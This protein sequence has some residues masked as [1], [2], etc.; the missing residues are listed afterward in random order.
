MLLIVAHRFLR[1]DLTKDW[2]AQLH[3][4]VVLLGLLLVATLYDLFRGRLRLRLLFPMVIQWA[5]WGWAGIT[6]VV[7]DGPATLRA[8]ATH[9]FTKDLIFATLISVFFDSVRKLKQLAWVFVAVLT[10]VALVTL[11]QRDG[12]RKCFHYRFADVLGYNQLADNRPCATAAECYNVPQ[13]ESEWKDDGWACEHEGP[14]GLATVIDRIHYVGNL[15]DPNAQAQALVMACALALGLLF[16]PQTGRE[17]PF[18]RTLIRLAL[19]AALVVM[20]LAVYYAASRAAQAALGVTLLCFFYTRIGPIGTLIGAAGGL[21]L[22]LLSRRNQVEAAY[23]TLTRIETQ[24]NGYMAFLDQ[25]L[26]GVGFGN[27]EK[28]SFITAHNSFLLSATEAGVIGSAL[29]VLAVYVSFKLLFQVVRWP[30]PEPE[31]EDDPDGQ[32]PPERNFAPTYDEN[33]HEIEEFEPDENDENDGEAGAAEIIE[34]KHL[35]MT[36]LSMLVGVGWCVTFLSLSYD[37]MWLFPVGIVA[38]FYGVSR[39]RLPEFEMRLSIWEILLVLLL[40]G[41]LPAIFAVI[42]TRGW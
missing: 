36:L 14:W 5:A 35:G 31:P 4:P 29:F 2:V 22:A 7:A 20:G 3:P 33:G 28:I 42:A 40:G 27:Y 37:V 24:V 15:A 23:S 34:L 9:D 17:S 16:W 26:F 1:L 8:F 10:L 12:D 6:K 32:G 11:P 30:V 39:D 41:L 38:A 19:F 13:G 18:W 25:P 21:P